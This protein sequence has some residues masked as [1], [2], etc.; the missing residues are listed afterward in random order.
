MSTKF[1]NLKNA[2][3]IPVEKTYQLTKESLLLQK[4]RKAQKNMNLADQNLILIFLE[5]DHFDYLKELHGQQ[6]M[7]SFTLIL[8]RQV[9]SFEKSIDIKDI[10]V[11]KENCFALIVLTKQKG[12]KPLL[13][14][15]YKICHICEKKG[16]M[17]NTHYKFPIHCTLSCAITE[18]KNRI[19]H[20]KVLIKSVKE[21]LKKAI[22]NGR[23]QII[24]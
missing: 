12:I 21:K 7:E 3:T 1:I 9:L 13:N 10:L 11:I 19:L 23:N 17:I 15:L 24:Y 22:V 8:K 18:T 4:I 2:C 14:W 5:I 16:L 20:E 6:I